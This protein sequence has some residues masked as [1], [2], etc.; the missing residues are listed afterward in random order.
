MSELNDTFQQIYQDH[1]YN[2]EIDAAYKNMRLPD[3]H[4]GSSNCWFLKVT[5]LNRGRGI[6]VFDTVDQLISLINECTES[7]EGTTLV[8]DSDNNRANTLKDRK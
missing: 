6:Y 7:I 3:T 1:A 8:R 5:K 2:F 4:L